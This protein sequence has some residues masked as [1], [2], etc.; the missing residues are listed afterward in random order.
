MPPLAWPLLCISSG[1]KSLVP[2]GLWMVITAEALKQNALI[3]CDGLDSKTE[4]DSGYSWRQQRRWF[5]G[6]AGLQNLSKKS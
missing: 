3:V 4:P 1:R 6:Y 5:F 2:L